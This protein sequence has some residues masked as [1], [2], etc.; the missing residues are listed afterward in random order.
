[1]TICK[2][3]SWNSVKNEHLWCRKIEKVF[4]ADLET[5]VV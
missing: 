1:M 4:I 3:K 2:K 5:D